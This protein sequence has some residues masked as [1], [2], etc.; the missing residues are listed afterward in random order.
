MCGVYYMAF[1]TFINHSVCRY[2]QNARSRNPVDTG[3][4]TRYATAADWIDSSLSLVKTYAN[5]FCGMVLSLVPPE[6]MPL[7]LYCENWEQRQVCVCV[8]WRQS[9]CMQWQCDW[10]TNVTKKKNKKKV[11]M[12]GA[13][14]QCT[15]VWCVCS[16]TSMFI[17]I[18]TEVCAKS[19]CVFFFISLPPKT[20]IKCT[21]DALVHASPTSQPRID[22]AECSINQFL[23]ECKSYFS[24]AL[25]RCYRC[26]QNPSIPQRIAWAMNIVKKDTRERL[27]NKW[28]V[29]VSH[30]SLHT[31]P[32]RICTLHIWSAH[33]GATSIVWRIVI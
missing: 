15:H 32:Q 21:C 27:A 16:R 24:C 4:R 13:E 26:R 3:T 22:C 33:L 6:P 14:E 23:W 20:H 29:R 5:E 9:L 8:A 12:D 31:T 1:G 17:R 18:W 7:L 25:C 30:R 19:A 11:R 10:C 2:F 28:N